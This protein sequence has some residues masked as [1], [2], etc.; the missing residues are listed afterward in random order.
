MNTT[1]QGTKKRSSPLIKWQ[2]KPRRLGEAV[3]TQRN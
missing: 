1:Y 3:R 2:A